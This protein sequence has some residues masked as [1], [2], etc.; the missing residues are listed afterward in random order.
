MNRFAY[1][2]FGSVPQIVPDRQLMHHTEKDRSVSLI[3][4][5]TWLES[6]LTNYTVIIL[7]YITWLT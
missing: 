5:A 1:K 7:H 3:S 6:A 4:R 2:K